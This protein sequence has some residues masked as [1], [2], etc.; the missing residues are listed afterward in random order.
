[1]EGMGNKGIHSRE[2]VDWGCTPNIFFTDSESPVT[3]PPVSNLVQLERFKSNDKK[4]SPKS[5]I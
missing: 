5:Q 1:M 3:A 2:G 4:A